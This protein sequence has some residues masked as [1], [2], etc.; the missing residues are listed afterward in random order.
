MTDFIFGS[1]KE[2]DNVKYDHRIQKKYN[3]PNTKPIIGFIGNWMPW[4]DVET[5]LKSSRYVE[6]ATFVVVGEASTQKSLKQLKTTYPSVIFTARIN[7]GD[8]VKLLNLMDICILPYKKAYIVKHLSV[9]KTLEYLAAG[10]PIVMSD[11]DAAD[12]QFLEQ[13]ENAVYYKAENPKDLALKIEYLLGNKKL[14]NH[15]KLSN[16]KLAKKF[17]WKNVVIN[18][19]ILRLFNSNSLINPH[20]I[21]KSNTNNFQ[22]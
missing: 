18:S 17:G 5:F 2:F 10:K 13:N 22:K 15:I 14:M 8:A 19:G 1:L 6:N 9:R 3:I 4:V 20:K 11:S 21:H 7:H 16:K 12:K